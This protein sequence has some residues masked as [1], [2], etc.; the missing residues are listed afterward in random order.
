MTNK[1][2]FFILMVTLAFLGTGCSKKTETTLPPEA[3]GPLETVTFNLG[4]V[5][6]EIEIAFTPQEQ[7]QGLMFRESMPENHGM[8][9]VYRQPRFLDFWMKNTWIPLD[10]AFIR[11][12]GIIGNIEAMK[13]Q[14]GK[15]V[16]EERYH[17]RYKSLYALE[18]NQGWFA[19]QGIRAGDK[20]EFPREEI[21]RIV[22]GKPSM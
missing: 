12:D 15:M 16:P 1:Q 11:E 9:F 2:F 21:E 22:A 17:S 3:L 13:P 18:M 5:V 4:N 19:K 14:Q 20:I 6:V 8:L 7:M 10:I